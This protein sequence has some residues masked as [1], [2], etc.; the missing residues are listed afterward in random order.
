MKV[1]IIFGICFVFLLIG[2]TGGTVVDEGE[3]VPFSTISSNTKFADV[4][5]PRAY[6]INYVDKINPHACPVVRNKT[7]DSIQMI[8]LNR[9]FELHDGG[10]SKFY[11]DRN[12]KCGTIRTE[13][14]LYC[15]RDNSTCLQLEANDRICN[16]LRLT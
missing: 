4:C 11:E 2:C 8:Y 16:I 13:G 1:V 9:S 6:D 12:M 5:V 3:A 14:K 7:L 10:I 15:L